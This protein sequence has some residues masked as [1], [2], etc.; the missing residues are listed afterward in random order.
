MEKMLD[1]LLKIIY[2]LFGRNDSSLHIDFEIIW[3]NSI[4]ENI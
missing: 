3:S 2:F 1:S 4:F